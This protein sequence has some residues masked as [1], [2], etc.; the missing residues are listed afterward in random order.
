MM[1]LASAAVAA[2]LLFITPFAFAEKASGT[3]TRQPYSTAGNWTVDYLADSTGKLVQAR[4]TRVWD[5]RTALRITINSQRTTL[6]WRG[7]G[8][9]EA[10]KEPFPVKYIW[11][12]G[13]VSAADRSS[14]TKAQAKLMQDEEGR[15]WA[16]VEV[17]TE[18][19]PVGI[20]D[21]FANAKKLQIESVTEAWSFDLVGSNPACKA[22][23]ECLHADHKAS[24]ASKPA[25]ADAADDAGE[26]IPLSKDSPAVRWD[27]KVPANGSKFYQIPVKKGQTITA[28]FLEDSKQGSADLG[29]YSLEEGMISEGK[30]VRLK[31][32]E[33][34]THRLSLNNPTAKT[35][36]FTVYVTVE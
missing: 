8:F 9:E 29:K 11:S 28:S 23:I 36:T 22:M 27:V 24:K 17:S 14:G 3:L 1:R 4:A 5:E 10:G 2:A 13:E 26:R 12:S 25:A 18:D 16:R 35:L 19:D 20:D 7:K 33:N 32:Q 21:G 34:T 30:G 31:S 6:D 15:S